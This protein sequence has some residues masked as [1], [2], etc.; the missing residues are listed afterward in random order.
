MSFS[1]T[2]PNCLQ[3]FAMPLAMVVQYHI[4]SSIELPG[5]KGGSFQ[6]RWNMRVPGICGA[7]IYF[8]PNRD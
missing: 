3:V 1:L 8:R 5:N 6:S 4:G 7:S 2:A